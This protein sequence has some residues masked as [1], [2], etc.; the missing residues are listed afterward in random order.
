MITEKLNIK[1]LQDTTVRALYK[2]RLN[3]KIQENNI[4]VEDTETSW[5]KIKQNIRNAAT[6]ALRKKKVN[7][8]PSKNTAPYTAGVKRLAKEKRDAYLKYLSG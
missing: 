7:K 8:N 3:Q 5:N 4:Q 1:L 6:E 2:N